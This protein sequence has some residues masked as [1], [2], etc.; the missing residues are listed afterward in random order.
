MYLL[1]KEQRE[2]LRKPLGKVVRE[3][4]KSEIEGM[5]ISKRGRCGNEVAE[6][7]RNKS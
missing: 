4:K 3:I 1:K 7:A 6:R 5:I 2:E